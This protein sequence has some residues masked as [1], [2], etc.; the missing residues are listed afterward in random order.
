MIGD[1]FHVTDSAQQPAQTRNGFQ[2]HQFR[3]EM[4]RVGAFGLHADE[5]I[6]FDQWRQPYVIVAVRE[7]SLARSSTSCQLVESVPGKAD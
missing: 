2:P 3:Q 6:G 5:A 4:N 7:N 1:G